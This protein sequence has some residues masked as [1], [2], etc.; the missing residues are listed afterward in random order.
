MTARKNYHDLCLQVDVLL[1]ACCLKLSEKNRYFFEWD[2]AHYLFTPGYSWD[3]V[4]RFTN[5][6]LKL[7][8]DIQ[9]Y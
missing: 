6:A 4:L 7:I 1:L 2:P 5:L 3:A 8:S 9:K